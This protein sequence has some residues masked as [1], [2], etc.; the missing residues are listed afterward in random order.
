MTSTL[1]S[2]PAPRLADPL[3]HRQL[4][5]FFEWYLLAA[6]VI[7]VGA[8]SYLLG[9]HIAAF[10]VVT[11]LAYLVAVY[12]IARIV[13]GGRMASNRLVSGL[14]TGAFLVA[15]LPL[16]SV[17][18]TVIDNG[19]SALSPEFFTASMRN[20]VTEGGGIYHAIWGTLIVTGLA[21]LISVPIGL[22]TAIYLVEY[23]TGMLAR[24]I[25]FLVDV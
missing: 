23:G 12:V 2:G 3:E 20:I 22:M 19:L 17:V 21:T 4:P 7:V 5:P 25:T 14:V 24:Q 16:V 13:E 6:T 8:V 15:L 18:W 10:V 1:Q 11:A 9:W